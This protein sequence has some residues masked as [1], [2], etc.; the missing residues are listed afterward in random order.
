MRYAAGVA[1]AAGLLL[2]DFTWFAFGVGRASASVC[3][4]LVSPAWRDAR[5]RHHA[6]LCNHP[7]N[8]HLRFLM[9]FV[10]IEIR[11]YFIESDTEVT[12]FSRLQRS[13][14]YQRAKGVPDKRPPRGTQLDVGAADGQPWGQ[15]AGPSAGLRGAWRTARRSTGPGGLAA[16][17]LRTLLRA[18]AQR[19]LCRCGLIRPWAGRC[20]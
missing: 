8:G 16:Q 11:R 1:S 2:S 20:R 10:R 13:V 14:V 12:P 6:V 5:H 15:A 7:V 18:G 3:L 19:Q 4:F 17:G 9:E